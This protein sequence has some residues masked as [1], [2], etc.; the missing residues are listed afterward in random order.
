MTGKNIVLKVNSR[1]VGEI[2]DRFVEGSGIDGNLLDIYA[3]VLH[4]GLVNPPLS[5]HCRL[6]HTECTSD[7]G[8]VL[9]HRHYLLYLR[10]VFIEKLI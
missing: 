1:I 7:V 10:T 3:L 8:N 6:D 4:V 5:L 9:N 2:S